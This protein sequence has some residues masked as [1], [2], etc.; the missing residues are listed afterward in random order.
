[1]RSESLSQRAI[2]GT[3]K[4]TRCNVSRFSPLIGDMGRLLL[5]FCVRQFVNTQGMLKLLQGLLVLL[6]S[7][8]VVA[9]ELKLPRASQRASVSQTVGLSEVSITY[10]RP[11]VRGRNIWGEL[12]PYGIV[13]RAGAN[14]ATTISFS[15][16]VTIDGQKLPAGTYSLQAILSKEQWTLI[17]NKVARQWGSFD[18]DPSQD[19]LRILVKPRPAEYEELLTFSIQ[20]VTQSSADVV[21]QWEKIKV[22]FNFEVDTISKV[23]P[24]V[25]AAVAEAKADDWNTPLRAAAWAFENGAVPDEALD[26]IEKSIAARETFENLSLKARLLARA[27]RNHEAAAV[28][29]RAIEAA[30]SATPKIDPGELE[31]W[32]ASLEKHSKS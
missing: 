22:S 5:N 14:E 20:R 26:W 1:M 12:I 9:A 3:P 18:Y 6:L 24:G 31:K 4:M 30:Q 8:P 21:L 2:F 17:F 19:A 16:D 13:W 23:L 15:D 11:A 27:G 32:L 29:R 7:V 10:S 25:R 28:A